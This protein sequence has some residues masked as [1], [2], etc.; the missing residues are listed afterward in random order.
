MRQFETLPENLQSSEDPPKEI[1]LALDLAKGVT[2]TAAAEKA[3]VGR[4]TV[5]RRLADPAF[6]KLV[7]ELR[8]E[9]MKNAL[10]RM[11]D[12]MSRAADVLTALLDTDQAAIRLRAA[13]ALLTLGP[14]LN[15]A[16]YIEERLDELEEEFARKQGLVP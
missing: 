3:G 6:R 10:G 16:V 7:A 5:Y 15:E 12:N 13:R 4:A 9:M 11:T 2:P 1:E 8:T 14:R